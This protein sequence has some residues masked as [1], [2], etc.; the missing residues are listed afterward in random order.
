MIPKDVCI[1]GQC[2]Q[3]A[4]TLV[5]SQCIVN[6]Y[7]TYINYNNIKSLHDQKNLLLITLVSVLHL[8]LLKVP[9]SR[10]AALFLF[11][12]TIFLRSALGCGRVFPSSSYQHKTK[13]PEGEIKVWTG[14]ISFHKNTKQNK[15]RKKQTE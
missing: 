6:F 13:K 12:I 2:Q 14:H 4:I 15:T 7:I 11:F 5:E 3:L 8:N 10:F 1:R 9:S